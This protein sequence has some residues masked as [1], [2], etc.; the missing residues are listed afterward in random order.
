[1]A[2]KI[3]SPEQIELMRKSAVL[4]ADTLALI[5]A[6]VKA[7]V[8]G[9]RLDKLAETH[10]RDNG[11][12]PSFK[13]LYGCP[14]SVLISVNEDVVHGIPNARSYKDGDIL[15]IDA[16]VFMNGFHADSAYTVG[17]G[18]VKP[19]T[20]KLMKVTK[21]ALYLGIE[22]AVAGNR[23]GMISSTI[24]EYCERKHGYRCVRELVGH[25]LGREL[26]EDPQVPNFGK[27]NDGPVLPENCV[28]A[29][30][31]MINL[32]RKDVYTKSDKWTVATQD[33]KPSA[34]FE[35]TVWIKKG[36]AEILTT[37]VPI[38]AAVKANSELVYV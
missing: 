23:V 18:N 7:G 2:I 20:I 32:G 34:H 12:V 26:H 21:E 9:L 37:F 6:E 8:N 17:I 29:I 30:E 38:E 22:K 11:G 19:E 13:G 14:S 1:M 4:L 31:P 24:Q 10:I 35:H 16:G 3:K 33:H 28:I 27:P 25:G 5:I 36:K 15:S